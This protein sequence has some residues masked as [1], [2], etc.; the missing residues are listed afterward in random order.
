MGRNQNILTGNAITVGA[1][2]AVSAGTDV[3]GATVDMSGYSNFVAFVSIAT[4]NAA[5]YIYVEGDD[6]SGMGTAVTLAGS[7]VVATVNG[8]VV[9]IE[10]VKPIHRYI[11]AVV[12]R[13]GANTATGELTYIRGGKVSTS[14]D[15]INTVAGVSLAEII[16]SPIEGT[17]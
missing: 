11:R 6:A 3:T 2:A 15:S 5:N 1:S 17:A 10:V 4:A 12:D 14:S 13:G 16:A 8:D 7:G 9:M